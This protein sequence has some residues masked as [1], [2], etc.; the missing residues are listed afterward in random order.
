MFSVILHVDNAVNVYAS[1]LFLKRD[2]LKQSL[3]N[4][5]HQS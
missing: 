3:K 2:N 4:F 5:I 1:I